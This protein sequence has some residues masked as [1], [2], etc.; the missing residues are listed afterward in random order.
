MKPLP[1]RNEI[2]NV[3]SPKICSLG[4]TGTEALKLSCG[5]RMALSQL[6]QQC[7][8]ELQAFT[9]HEVKLVQEATAIEI[10]DAVNSCQCR[11]HMPS[12]GTLVAA[13]VCRVAVH[14]DRPLCQLALPG[15]QRQQEELEPCNCNTF[16]SFGNGFQESREEEGE[17][18]LANYSSSDCGTNTKQ[19]DRAAACWSQEA[20]ASAQ[21]CA[22][23][24]PQV[25]VAA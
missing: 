3:R 18:V 7:I 15:M 12:P 8:H 24:A 10:Q 16:C 13:G 4:Q 17:Q 19:P 1:N 6:L 5:C 22:Q 2:S 14:E 25:P 11:G 9:H 20:R 21:C 23:K